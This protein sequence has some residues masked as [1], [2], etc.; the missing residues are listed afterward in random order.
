MVFA[1]ASAMTLKSFIHINKNSELVPVDVEVS[2]IKGLPAIYFIGLADAAIKESA[3]KI[4]SA[5]RRQGFKFPT[6]QQIIVNLRP[7][8]LKKTS[9]GLDLPVALAILLLTK[10]IKWPEHLRY[11]EKFVYGELNLEGEVQCPSDIKLHP[12]SE[13]KMLITGGGEVAQNLICPSYQIKNLRNFNKG[14]HV[15]GA[16]ILLDWQR[17]KLEKI[18]FSAKQARLMEIIA[19]GEHSALLVGPPGRGKTTIANSILNILKQPSQ[20]EFHHQQKYM[21]SP[22]PCT[23]RTLISP[24]HS[25]TA[26][27]L[28][29]GGNL[30]YPG[31]ITRAHGGVLLMDEF[32]EFDQRVFEALR[33]PVES[34]QITIARLGERR[35]YPCKFLLLATTN[36]CR[37]GEFVPR[38][39]NQC[40]CSR[41]KRSEYLARFRGPMI[42]RFSLIAFA[43]E[44]EENLSVELNI[45]ES[46]VR[47]A[48]EFALKVRGQVEL[49]RDIALEPRDVGYDEG[50]LVKL[51]SHLGPSRR[52]L[53]YFLQ[54]ARTIADLDGCIEIDLWHLQEASHF[55]LQS[56]QILTKQALLY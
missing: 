38:L 27:S 43:D 19:T 40:Q 18:F 56:H 47:L 17:P 51:F 45:I 8:H 20:E 5:I 23:W 33:E 36:L 46:H 6:S 22:R 12:L 11:E 28:I 55:C 48:Q 32:L 9:Q 42:D 44:W 1:F 4:K 15:A 52:R 41:R 35:T 25:I 10:Q 13:N 29:G 50:E 54:V 3:I 16:K 30:P 39:Q 37:C 49:N 14:A 24:H 21:V 31:E 53:K 7:N 26:R 2:L 34:H